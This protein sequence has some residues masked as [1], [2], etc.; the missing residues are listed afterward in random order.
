MRSRWFKMEEVN[1]K[2]SY[3]MESDNEKQTIKQPV[4]NSLIK[5]F[6]EIK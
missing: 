2:T 4:F 5:K 6:L 3:N 1:T